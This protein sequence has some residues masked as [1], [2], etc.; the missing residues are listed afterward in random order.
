MQTGLLTLLILLL[1]PS[2]EPG[3]HSAAK[4]RATAQESERSRLYTAPHKPAVPS[5][6]D[7]GWARNPLDAF[8]LEK[9]QAAGLSP[10]G[11][12]DKLTLLRRVTF[13]LTGLLPTVEEQEAFLADAT[14][15]AYCKMVERLLDS[16]HYGERWAQHWLDLVRYAET[17]GFKAD[18]LRPNAF[19]YR[20]YVIQALNEDLPFDRFIRQQLAGDELE[21][22]NPRALIATGFNRLYPDEYNAANLEQRRQEILDDVTDV[23][24]SVFLGLTVGC[25]RCHDHKFDPILQTDYY[26]LQA[27][28]AAMRPREDLPAA[29]EEAIRR[30]NERL[31]AWEKAT[32]DIRREMDRLTA[33]KRRDL[34]QRALEKFRPEI[35]Q[36]VLTE[37][38]KRTPYQEQIALLAELQLNRAEKEAALKLPPDKKERYQE[39][40]RLL[41]AAR[42]Q[43]PP[44][45][46]VAMAVTDTGRKPPP[47]HRLAG[48]DWR[49]P[50]EELEPGFPEFLSTDIP[51][52]RLDGVEQSTGRRAALARWLTRR[53]NPLTA[54]VL[55]NRLW[56]HHFGIGIVATPND[57]GVQGEPA[58]HPEL[59]DWLASEF[60]DHGWS[61]KHMHRLMVLSATYRQTS[62]IDPG[63]PEQAKAM[64][65]DHENKLLWHARRRRLE[66]EALRDTMLCLAGELNPRMFGASARPRLPD[67]ISNYAW[68]PDADP[69]DQKRRSIYV[70]AK[71]NM[72]YPM[73]DAFDL[74]DMHNSCARRTQTTTAPQA[75]LMLNSDFTLERARQWAAAL[76]GHHANLPDVIALAY[77]TAWGR[78]A[79]EEEIRLGL[80]FV[81]K[82]IASSS[83]STA[84]LDAVADFCHALLNANEFLYVD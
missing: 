73:F 42:P 68:K 67:H 28:F 48:G 56:Q 17:D 50:H 5:A 55:V 20:D 37:A 53:D 4:A 59:L 46:P 66:G 52:T 70:F 39:L 57:F 63:R 64:K 47:T 51:D 35:Q 49:K 12:A 21:P 41:A 61:L 34:R 13:D 74:P 45:L 69:N 6:G 25:A 30:H 32:A 15:D 16:P 54:R 3:G 75:L 7:G 23:T 78:P 11:P 26:R 83:A 31:A 18:D 8:V 72:R 76:L 19:R 9:L 36:A 65:I 22:R 77:R 27:F 43:K 79:T 14:P 62:R 71:R 24:G 84:H 60:M 1:F 38:D 80:E 44:P 58:T 81:R 82:E 29:S 33:V 40:E 2:G 10:S